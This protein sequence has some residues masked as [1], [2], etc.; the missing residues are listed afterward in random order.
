MLCYLGHVYVRRLGAEQLPQLDAEQE[1]GPFT[2]V[3][4]KQE[5]DAQ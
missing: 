2:V 1:G 5:R 3:Q 4:E